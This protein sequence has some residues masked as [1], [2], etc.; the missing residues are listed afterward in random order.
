MGGDRS[1]SGS[2]LGRTEEGTDFSIHGLCVWDRVRCHCRNYERPTSRP[3][4]RSLSAYRNRTWRHW[5]H[6]LGGY[7]GVPWPC[8][9]PM[10]WS[11]E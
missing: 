1:G 8:F 6:G 3:S 2:L 5:T 11:D 9:D 10:G 4:D 7:A